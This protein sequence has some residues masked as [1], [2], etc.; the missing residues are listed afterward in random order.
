MKDYLGLKFTRLTVLKEADPIP[1]NKGK[2]R[3]AY[4]CRC[5]CGK[6]IVVT[7]HQ[8][9][10]KN[11]TKSCGCLNAENRS[12]LGLSKRQYEPH[13]ASARAIFGNIYN[14]GNL[15]FEKFY[16]LSQLNCHYCNDSPNNTYN[17]YLH[18]DKWSKNSDFAKENGLFTY[19]GLD[20]IDSS[21]PHDE[22]N[23]VPCCLSCNMSKSNKTVEE[24]RVW[25]C[26]VYEFWA[27][28]RVQ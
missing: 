28:E 27:K 21:K 6:E 3:I 18:R 15:S 14:D 24:F 12:K 26:K 5:D 13:I 10:N 7:R 23:V 22:D 19:N 1:D 11:G 8:L 9:Q 16:E 20:R 2:N 25:L 17:K 4:L